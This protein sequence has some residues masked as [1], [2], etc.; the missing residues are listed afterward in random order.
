MNEFEKIAK[1]TLHV[2]EW[3]FENTVKFVS[4][5]DETIKDEPPVK[6]AIVGLV[7]AAERA[8]TDTAT[9]AASKGANVPADI[10][11]VTDAESFFA[12]F[13]NS[14]LPVVESAYKSLTADTK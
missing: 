10:L 2:I 14:F 1:D 3:P 8:I 11:A 5:V 13:K 6:A 12:Y 7:A 9:A 4:L